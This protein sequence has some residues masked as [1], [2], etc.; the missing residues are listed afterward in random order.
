MY[1][2]KEEGYISLGNG[3]SEIHSILSVKDLISNLM[4]D[5]I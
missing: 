1:K 3:I 5:F 4:Q 2:G